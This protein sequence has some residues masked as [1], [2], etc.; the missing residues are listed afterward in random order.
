LNVFV[1]LN[2][3]P[4]WTYTVNVFAEASP[5]AQFSVPPM[6]VYCWPATALPLLV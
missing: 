6:L 1:P 2:A 4:L 5:L 3:V